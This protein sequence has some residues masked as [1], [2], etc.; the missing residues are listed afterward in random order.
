MNNNLKIAL[1]YPIDSQSLLSN[2]ISLGIASIGAIALKKNCSVKVFIKSNL[3]IS[4]K[5]EQLVRMISN[6]QP[7]IIGITVLDGLSIKNIYKLTRKLKTLNKPLIAGG[8]HASVRPHE[9]LEYGSFDIVI[10][11]EGE[12][13]FSEVIEYFKGQRELPEILGIS[14]KDSSNRLFDNPT[15]PLILNL[16]ELPFPARELF[17]GLGFDEEAFGSIMASRGCPYRC[18]FCSR[19]VF[20]EH[21]RSRSPE[22]ILAEMIEIRNEFK[23]NRYVFWD[24]CF[25]VDLKW[26]EKLMNLI[27]NSPQLKG[28]KW[29]CSGGRINLASR[30]IL[31]KMKDAGCESISFGIETGDPDMLKK[32]KKCISINEIKDTVKWTN[33]AGIYCDAYIMYGFPDENLASLEKTFQLIKEL[34]PYV[35][36]WSW[37]GILIP[38]AGTEIYENYNIYYHFTDWWLDK[39]MAGHPYYPLY[40]KMHFFSDEILQK[41]FFNYSSEIKKKI[42]FIQHYIGKHNFKFRYKNPER[43]IHL[44]FSEMSLFFSKRLRYIDAKILPFLYSLTLGLYKIIYK[45]KLSIFTRSK[46]G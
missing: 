41:D 45:I 16:D 34:S 26:L 14:Y 23:V 38:H 13:T 31:K 10:R 2:N 39:K 12:Q 27:I 25:M 33:K 19:T 30:N 44:S 46:K 9:I 29:H 3:K 37:F 28:I 21:Y 18:T 5:N 20:G 4:Y 15:R 35:R 17:K 36:I 24:D 8:P 11:G 42:R 32:I 40:S 43:L 6:Y 7:D 22:N 1:L